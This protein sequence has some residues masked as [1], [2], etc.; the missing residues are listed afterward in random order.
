MSGDPIL[1]FTPSGQPITLSGS[2][3]SGMGGLT[4]DTLTVTGTMTAASASFMGG[5]VA[6]SEIVAAGSIIAGKGVG[7]FGV[8]PPASQP[9]TPVSLADVIALL[10]SY[11]LSA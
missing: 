6:A 5:P 7:S 8:T 2:A 10:Q 4:V 3:I 11:G 9:A 1:G